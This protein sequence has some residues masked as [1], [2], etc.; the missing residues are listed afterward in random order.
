MKKLSGQIC[1]LTQK[2][3]W[4]LI[5]HLIENVIVVLNLMKI[6]LLIPNG[7]IG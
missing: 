2:L 7:K 3:P 6:L 4:L 5:E 1:T